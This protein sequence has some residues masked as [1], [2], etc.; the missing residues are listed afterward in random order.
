M[1]LAVIWTHSMQLTKAQMDG[2]HNPSA[3]KWT[4]ILVPFIGGWFAGLANKKH[5]DI[6]ES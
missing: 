5:I 1:D 6:I 4:Y 3:F 2:D